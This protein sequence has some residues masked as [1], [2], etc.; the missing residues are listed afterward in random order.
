MLL[1]KVLIIILYLFIPRY[2]CMSDILLVHLFMYNIVAELYLSFDE[3]PITPLKV[4]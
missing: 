3:P 4:S 2:V 1:L